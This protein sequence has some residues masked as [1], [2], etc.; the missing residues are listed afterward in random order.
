[1]SFV[2]KLMFWKHEKDPLDFE[3]PLGNPSDNH[4]TPSEDPL[5]QSHQD[6]L[7]DS[8]QTS[9]D[10]LTPQTQ[11]KYSVHADPMLPP[12]QSVPSYSDGQNNSSGMNKNVEFYEGGRSTEEWSDQLADKYRAEYDAKQNPSRQQS[13][14][15]QSGDQSFSNRDLEVLNLKIDAVKSEVSSLGHQLEKIERLIKDQKKSW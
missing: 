3:D 13:T 5:A 15:Q 10:P 9:T 8:F 4:I 12:E 2:D 14:D 1:M 11:D 6:P 7:S